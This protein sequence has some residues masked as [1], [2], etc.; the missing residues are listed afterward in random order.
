[1]VGVVRIALSLEI[2]KNLFAHKRHTRTKHGM[3]YRGGGGGNGRWWVVV[4][5]VVG[6]AVVVVRWWYSLAM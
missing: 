3:I 4:S 1:M 6:G 5:V 2:T